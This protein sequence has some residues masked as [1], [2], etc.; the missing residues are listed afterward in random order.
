M[1]KTILSF[2]HYTLLE[3]WHTR[4][5]ALLFAV[6]GL[7]YF[8]TVFLSHITLTETQAMQVALSAAFLRL[9]GIYLLC[10]FVISSMVREQQQTTVLLWFSLPVARWQYLLGRWLGYAGLAAIM[11][12]FL[13]VFLL[14][15]APIKG[16]LFWALSLWFELLILLSISLLCVLT[17]PHTVLAFSAV[18]AFYL[19]ARSI[20]T[21][22]LMATGILPNITQTVVDQWIA[23][24]IQVLALLLPDLARFTK[25]DWLLDNT[26]AFDELSLLFLQTLIYLAVILSAALFDLYRKNW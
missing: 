18:A 17:L 1:L 11:V 23:G 14:A 7:A 2:S 24:F 21:I 22:E 4:T 15:F 10:L 12:I 16:V 20:H 8:L 13:A 3:A 25:T 5:P 6:L 9:T 26:F 19:L